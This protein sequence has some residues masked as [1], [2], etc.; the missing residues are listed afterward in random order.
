MKFAKSTRVNKDLSISQLYRM[1][2][3]NQI[4]LNPPYQRASVWDLA[5]KQKFVDSML[6]GYCIPDIILSCT[7]LGSETKTKYYN[8]IDGKQRLN[9]IV[10][11]KENV[12]AVKIGDEYFKYD[13]LPDKDSF[14]DSI[15]FSTKVYSN[16]TQEDEKEIFSRLQMGVQAT[17]ME[18]IRGQ[19]YP[20]IILAR[21][22]IENHEFDL[23]L[24]NYLSN[25]DTIRGG[26]LKLIITL[27]ATYVG[28]VVDKTSKQKLSEKSISDYVAKIV[29]PDTTGFVNM[30]RNLTAYTPNKR[31]IKRRELLAAI[32]LAKKIMIMQY[33]WEYLA[34]RAQLARA[35][36]KLAPTDEELAAIIGEIARYDCGDCYKFRHIVYNLSKYC[37]RNCAEMHDAVDNFARNWIKQNIF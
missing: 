9:T 36:T 8:N 1:V 24:G 27:Y 3:S 26:N 19:D 33:H 5:R 37:F 28:D 29:S 22:I 35:I 32:V 7:N 25:K 31:M 13:D 2:K 6:N 30:L 16:I 10:E 12:F 4:N 17:S 21:K 20:L 15:P 18:T 11:F 14:D 23:L 34:F